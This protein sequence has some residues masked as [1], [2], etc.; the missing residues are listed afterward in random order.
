[1]K[2]R[3]VVAIAAVAAGVGVLVGPAAGFASADDISGGACTDLDWAIDYHA[4]RAGTTDSSGRPTAAAVGSQRYLQT[5]YNWYHQNN[6][7]V[8]LGKNRPSFPP[9]YLSTGCSSAYEWPERDS[10]DHAPILE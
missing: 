5:L 2:R 9:C 10:P 3:L 4:W 1:M 6:C 8:A 7:N